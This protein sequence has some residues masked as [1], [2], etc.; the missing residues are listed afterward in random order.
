VKI[1]SADVELFHACRQTYGRTQVLQCAL[2]RNAN[3]TTGTVLE[4]YVCGD[5]Y[6]SSNELQCRYNKLTATDSKPGCYEYC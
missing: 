6:V 2:R 1:C 5:S 3:A 4:C